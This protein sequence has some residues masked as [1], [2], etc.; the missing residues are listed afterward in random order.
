MSL[1]TT[2][3]VEQSRAQASA[4]GARSS[5]SRYMGSP[6]DRGS[7]KPPVRSTN[8]RSGNTGEIICYRCGVEVH[9]IRDFL[10]PW[11]DKCYQCGQPG[12]IGMNCTQGPT[13]ASSVGSGVGGSK[14]TTESAR[15]GQTTTSEPS[16]Q[17]QV[18]AMT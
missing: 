4:G 3:T 11:A 14:G 18:Y 12:C 7:W 2:T 10:M 1:E 15:Q 9:I 8:S 6:R 17:D 5:S 13:T 16:A